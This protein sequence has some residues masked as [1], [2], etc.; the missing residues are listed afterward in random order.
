MVKVCVLSRSS[1][2]TMSLAV[3][4]EVA[5]GLCDC[6]VVERKEWLKATS[7]SMQSTRCDNGKNEQGLNN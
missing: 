1:G 6:N 4:R 7:N 3:V 2:E 5:R